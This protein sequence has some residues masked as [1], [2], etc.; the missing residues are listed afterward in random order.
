MEPLA[1]PQAL[2]MVVDNHVSKLCMI[3]SF[4]G[5]YRPYLLLFYPGNTNVG[6]ILT[7]IPA[8]VVL[9]LGFTHLC[10]LRG[11]QLETVK[12]S[13]TSVPVVSIIDTLLYSPF[14]ITNPFWYILSL[15]VVTL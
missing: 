1:L 5:F 8:T 3:N 14:V 10:G 11:T 13:V 12:Y 7:P 2:H 9:S 4:G 6:T 15:I